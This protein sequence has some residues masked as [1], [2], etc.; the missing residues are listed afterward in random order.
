[1]GS[2]FC[3]HYTGDTASEPAFHAEEMTAA[4]IRQAFLALVFLS[5]VVS[6]S[7]ATNGNTKTE[8]RT[9][10]QP[11]VD[12]YTAT[13]TH[14]DLF[15]GDLTK[16]A[17]VSFTLSPGSAREV[18]VRLDSSPGRWHGCLK[19]LDRFVCDVEPPIDLGLVT[20][21]EVRARG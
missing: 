2:G 15:A 11:E 3:R 10:P 9:L 16:V 12:G 19:R 5:L 17:R 21:F 7:A 18:W 14:Y 6:L 4:V 1:M 20:R 13:N 8:T